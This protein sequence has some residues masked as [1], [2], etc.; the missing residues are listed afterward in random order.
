MKIVVK[1]RMQRTHQKVKNVFL[2]SKKENGMVL[3]QNNQN[4]L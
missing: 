4:L 1:I 2:E 3:F